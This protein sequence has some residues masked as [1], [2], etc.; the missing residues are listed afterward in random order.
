MIFNNILE[1]RN[2]ISSSAEIIIVDILSFSDSKCP[3][4]DLNIWHPKSAQ[5]YRNRKTRYYYI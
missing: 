3:F 2:T 1:L 4:M 5:F